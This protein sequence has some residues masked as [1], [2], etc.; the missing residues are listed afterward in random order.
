MAGVYQHCGLLAFCHHAQL[1][2][3]GSMPWTQTRAV[4]VWGKCP[5]VVTEAHVK[6]YYKYDSAS[7]KFVHLTNLLHFSNTADGVS[8]HTDKQMLASTLPA[9][10][11]SGLLP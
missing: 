3:V 4:R 9:G 2:T 6:S 10:T 8:L 5:E 7:R 1:V 11:V